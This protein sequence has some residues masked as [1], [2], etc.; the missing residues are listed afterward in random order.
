M[1]T[2]RMVRS[3]G[4]GS[5]ERSGHRSS[6]PS[7]KPQTGAG[8]DAF[9]MPIRPTPSASRIDFGGRR[10]DTPA[11]GVRTRGL[12]IKAGAAKLKADRAA[13]LEGRARHRSLELAPGH[14]PRP[15]VV[16]TIRAALLAGTRGWTSLPGLRHRSG[17]RSAHR[18]SS[19]VGLGRHSCARAA[20]L[21]VSGIG[22]DAEAAWAVRF[23][24]SHGREGPLLVHVPKVEMSSRRSRRH[25][26]GPS[27]R[28]PMP[29]IGKPQACRVPP[30]RSRA[31]ARTGHPTV[32]AV[33]AIEKD[34][35]RPFVPSTNTPPRHREC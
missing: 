22:T 13:R 2:L 31:E 29:R 17:D 9:R 11:M 25:L 5:G 7:S 4:G 6:G 18:R 30:S 20:V 24:A 1:M 33:S 19:P 16:P 23:A 10:P 32:T 15:A 35:S 21:M 8:A 27:R 12:D 3:Q 28:S 26:K 14:R 34:R